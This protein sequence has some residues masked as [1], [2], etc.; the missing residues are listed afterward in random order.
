MTEEQLDLLRMV[1]NRADSAA[2]DLDHRIEILEEGSDSVKIQLVDDDDRTVSTV[3]WVRYL[4]PY[5]LVDGEEVVDNE[6]FGVRV[7]GSSAMP[8]W[9]I[10]DA[11]GI[12]LLAMLYV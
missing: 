3:A 8:R 12:N 2:Q 6:L 4:G 1:I 5:Q 9:R 7:E 11:R 10:I